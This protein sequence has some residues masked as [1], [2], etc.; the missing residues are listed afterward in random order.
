MSKKQYQRKDDTTAEDFTIVQVFGLSLEKLFVYLLAI[1]SLKGMFAI[2]VSLLSL[3]KSLNCSKIL[4]TY[5]LIILAVLNMF[6][7]DIMPR[8]IF[9]F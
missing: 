1:L 8:S 3:A 5:L 9:R 2:F 6:C 4:I 7:A